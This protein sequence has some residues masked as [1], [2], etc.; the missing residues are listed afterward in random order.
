MRYLLVDRILEWKANETARG[1][2][3]VAMTE[4]FLEFHFPGNPVMPGVLMVEALSQLAGWL[5]AAS[6]D[7]KGWFLPE[8]VDKCKFYG[9]ALPGDQVELTVEAVTVEQDRASFKAIGTV[10]GKKKAVAEFSGAIVP[11]AEIADVDKERRFFKILTR[12]LSL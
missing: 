9:F 2:K 10:M 12:E 3:N 8:T 6:S 11:L 5:T 4:D 1:I 7:F